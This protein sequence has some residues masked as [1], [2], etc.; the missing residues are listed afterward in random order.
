MLEVN[1]ITELVA[2][3]KQSAKGERI[4]FL[5]EN[6]LTDHKEAAHY[7]K[8]LGVPITA[9]YAESFADWKK[10]FQELQEKVDILINFNFASFKD[11]DG[12][13]AAAFAQKH[14]KIPTGAF[15][16]EAMPHTIVGYLKVPEEQG[17]WAAQ[18]A[19]KILDGTSPAAIP[20]AKNQKGM[21]MV[22]AKLAGQA[23]VEI[24]YQVIEVAEK[25]IE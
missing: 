18:T 9:Y 23:G 8:L 12:Q 3:L 21:I 5:G 11:W 7:E 16:E 2:L 20:V 19:L 17:E 24:P 14:G 6:T 13:E 1:A 4:G 22:N 10:G 15:Q 25:V